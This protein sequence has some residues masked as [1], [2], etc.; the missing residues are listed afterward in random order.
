M[1]SSGT[2]VSQDVLI[3]EGYNKVTIHIPREVHIHDD[4]CGSGCSMHTSP[5][6]VKSGSFPLTDSVPPDSILLI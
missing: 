6:V 4:Y 3:S 5:I 2:T 1:I